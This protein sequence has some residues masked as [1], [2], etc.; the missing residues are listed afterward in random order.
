MA[1]KKKLERADILYPE[2]SYRVVGALFSVFN[3]LGYGYREKYYQRAI[4]QELA[5]ARIPFKQQIAYEIK[6]KNKIIGRQILDFLIDGKI[7][8]ELKR[9]NRFSKHDIT[10]VYGYLKATNLKL[11]ILARFSSKGVIFK[12]IVNEQ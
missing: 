9:G 6:F 11:A 5:I 8:L 2:L 3:A 10:Q 12:R 7:V 4:A 1:E